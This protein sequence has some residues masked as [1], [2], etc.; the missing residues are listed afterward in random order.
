M[1]AFV[2]KRRVRLSGT[3]FIP[4]A[5]LAAISNFFRCLLQKV[6]NML[7]GLGLQPGLCFNPVRYL[8]C[9]V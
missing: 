8:N 6:V 9:G 2:Y 3:K 4:S 1:E 5:E 7:V